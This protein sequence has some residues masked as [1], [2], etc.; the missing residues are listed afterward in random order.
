MKQKAFAP[1][2]ILSALACVCIPAPLWEPVSAPGGHLSS[3]LPQGSLLVDTGPLTS[4]D[5]QQHLLTNPP[6]PT[7]AASTPSVC[8]SALS[9]GSGSACPV[10]AP[11]PAGRWTTAQ[12]AA[13]SPLL[14]PQLLCPGPL[15]DPRLRPSELCVQPLLPTSLHQLLHSPVLPAV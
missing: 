6:A 14:R 11:A 15:P 4:P 8:S 1:M 5:N 12:R 7:T 10:P 13:A 2:V 3:H 9:Y